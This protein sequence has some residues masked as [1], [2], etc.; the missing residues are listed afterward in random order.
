[1][2]DFGALSAGRGQPVEPIVDVVI[3][4]EDDSTWSISW[5]E[6]R[7]SVVVSPEMIEW[8][9]HEHNVQILVTGG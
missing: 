8:I 1:M 5:P 9:V 7:G 3:T 4:R 6:G 2:S